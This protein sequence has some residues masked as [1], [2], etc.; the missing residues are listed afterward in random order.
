VPLFRIGVDAAKA[1]WISRFRIVDAG[2]GY[3]HLPAVSWCDEELAEQ[4]T[5]E[6]LVM[7][8]TKGIP[9]E[10]WEQKRARND[11]LDCA[12]Y[13]LAALRLLHPDL[14]LLSRRLEGQEPAPQ[15]VKP[16]PRGRAGWLGQGRGDFLKR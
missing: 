9:R 1:L 8:W 12:V 4:L 3:V 7:K 15:A 16:A 2:P 10:T 14:D 13:G 6:R 5:S 11:A